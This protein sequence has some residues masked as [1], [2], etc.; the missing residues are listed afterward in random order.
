MIALRH[1]HPIFRRRRFL[2][3]VVREDSD[4][5][6]KDVEWLGTD[7]TEMTEEDW[8][9]PQNKCL[10]MFLN[11]SA[12]PEPTMRGERIV[13]DSAL[14]MFNASGNE[15]EFVLPGEEYGPEWEV[16]IGTGDTIDVGSVFDAGEAVVRPSHSLLILMRPPV[17]AEDEDHPVE[18]REPQRER[19]NRA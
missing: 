10:T 12:I 5:V 14:V 15:V 13:G 1:E 19:T 9:D 3:G 16:V 2:Q 4:S 17:E 6:L 11:G 18:D 8:N 7:G